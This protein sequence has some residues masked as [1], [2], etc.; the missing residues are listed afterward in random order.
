MANIPTSVQFTEA[1]RGQPITIS[2]EAPGD[3]TNPTYTLQRST[4][5]T[6]D[7]SSFTTIYTGTA[8]SFTETVGNNW[9]SVM[10]RV[11]AT[12]GGSTSLW[13]Y[14]TYQDIEESAPPTAPTN[15]TVTP[16]TAQAGQTLTFSW[17]ASTGTFSQYRIYG[18]RSDGSF[19]PSVYVDKS[20]LTAT[21]TFPSNVPDGGYIRYYVYAADDNGANVGN[22]SNQVYVYKKAAEPEPEPPAPP[23]VSTSGRLEQ[24]E[25]PQGEKVFPKTTIDGVFRAS[26]GKSLETILSEIETT[27][28][29]K[30]ETGETG[31][32]GPAGPGVPTGGTA[33]QVLT[34][35]S[36]T[37]YDTQWTTLITIGTSDLT[38]GSSTLAAGTLYG[39]YE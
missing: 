3:A 23:P 24:F 37:D 28:G 22:M 4:S 35:K 18:T 39:V 21:G 17:N 19:A 32:T 30:G 31:A 10:Y 7:E 29:P 9:K 34:K 11:N 38:A 8:R 1:V 5:T 20:K 16:T 2:W 14:S 33:R 12:Y 15:F 25:N 36:G 6:F 27:P 13:G 26:D